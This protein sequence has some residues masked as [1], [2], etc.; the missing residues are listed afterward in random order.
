M[1]AKELLRNWPTWARANAET[2]LASPAWRMPVVFDGAETSLTAV[3]S[4]TPSD[5]DELFLDVT[6]DGERYVVGLRDTELFGDL[7]LLWARRAELDP[8]LLLAVVEKDCGRLFQLI[9]DT[10][11]KEFA[12]IGLAASESAGR[13]EPRRRFA[14][15][16]L[17][18][19]IDLSPMLKILFGRLEYLDPAHESIRALTRPA[20]YVHASVDVPDDAGAALAEGD[21]LV[22]AGSGRDEWITEFP[23]DA[24]LHVCAAGE[25]DVSFAAFADG[26]MP[27]PEGKEPPVLVR[28]GRIV[29]EGEFSTIGGVRCFR[30]TRLLS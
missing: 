5:G 6:L 18:F 2:I 19:S 11:R 23:D 21:A 9:E 3:D 8:N 20:R 24:R 13:G 16:G 26:A 25:T 7:H 29:A 4:A 12:V 28:N 30:L 17:E 15:P 10:V 1:D 27:S 14:V 22:L